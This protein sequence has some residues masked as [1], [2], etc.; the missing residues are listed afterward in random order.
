M[1][2]YVYKTGMFEI[3]LNYIYNH[4]NNSIDIKIHQEQI[5][6]KYYDNNPFFKIKNVNYTFLNQIGKNLQVID[7]KIKPNKNFNSLFNINVIQ[8]NGI[9]IM[10]DIHEI[11]LFSEKDN[12]SQNFPLRTKIRQIELKQR[13]KEFIQDLI[14]NTG[15][16]KIFTIDEIEE[17]IRQNPVLWVRVDSELS[18]LCINKINQEHILYEYIK[19]FKEG[20]CIGQMESLYNIGKNKTYYEKSLQILKIFIICP[21]IYYKIRQYAL[22]IFVKIIKKLKKEEEYQFLLDKFDDCYN[23]LIK[24]KSYLNLDVYYIMKDIIKYLGEYNENYFNQFYDNST[25]IQNK[26]INKF[27][28]FLISNELN[29][30]LGFNDCYIM[31]EIL[32]YSSKFNLKEKSIIL[33]EKIL[34]YLRTEKLKRSINEKILISCFNALINLLITNEF[35]FFMRKNYKFNITLTAIFDEVNYF[36]NNE[37]ENYELNIFI[38]Y[39]QIFMIF[40][41]SQSYI[42]FS[43]FLIKFVLGDE[44]NNTAKMAYF[45]CKKNLDMISKIKTLYFFFENNELYFDSLDDKIIFL[46]SLQTIL[47]SPICYLRGDCRNVLEYL[48]E[49][50]YLKDISEIGAGNN[51]FNNANFLHLLNRNWVNFTSRKYADED[52]LNNFINE[53]EKSMILESDEDDEKKSVNK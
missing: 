26:I 40:Y 24:N 8:T 27:L 33:L 32:I 19:I 35:F 15:I 39:F 34:K 31:S 28:S 38:N 12:V 52:W 41:K 21:N 20:D 46:S 44:Y 42:E 17:I 36:I 47:Y 53:K 10:N 50:F 13:Q 25:P 45:S 6:K 18:S 9:T 1:D 3:S 48:Y 11:Q 7:H 37:T 22:K 43:N 51:N 30:I 5:A 29:L 2:I 16:D 4:K 23:E 49:K 14:V